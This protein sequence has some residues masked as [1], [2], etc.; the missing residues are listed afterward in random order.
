MGDYADIYYLVRLFRGHRS[1]GI[2]ATISIP[3]SQ[4]LVSKYYLPVK[5]TRALKRNG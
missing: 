1:N 3:S 5:E 2:P 4:I